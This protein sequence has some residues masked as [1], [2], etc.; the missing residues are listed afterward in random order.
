MAT[1]C[2]LQVSSDQTRTALKKREVKTPFE[3]NL[4]IYK[5]DL[6]RYWPEYT[7]FQTSL[8]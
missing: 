5:E 4:L 1:T 6:T 2:E 8:K 7:K 3:S